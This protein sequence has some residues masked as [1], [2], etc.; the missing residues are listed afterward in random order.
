VALR[1]SGRRSSDWWMYRL[2][3]RKRRRGLPFKMTF[4]ES[5]VSITFWI[6]FGV[7]LGVGVL[8]FRS[9]I[10]IGF[11]GYMSFGLQDRVCTRCS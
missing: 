11:Y 5:N 3:R 8:S 9:N 4:D 6:A 10:D 2:V 7:F 1:V